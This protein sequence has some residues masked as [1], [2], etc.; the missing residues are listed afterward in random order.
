MK[1]IAYIIPYFGKLPKNFPLWLL[2]CKKNPTV[3]FILLTN[4]ETSYQY[5]FN[6]KVIYCT[7]DSIKKRFQEAFNFNICIDRPWRLSLFKPAYGEIFTSEL[8]DYDFWG[9]C[10]VDLM[11]GN[12]RK[13]IT[14]EILDSYERI[15]TKGHSTLIKNC[16]KVNR[17]Y[18]TEIKGMISYKEVFSG[19]TNYSFDENGMDNIYEALNIKYYFSPNYAHLEKYEP[20]FYLKRLPTEKLYTNKYQVF[21]WKQGNLSRIYL[22]DDILFSEDYMY[23]HFFCRPMNYK[24]GT[25]NAE[26][27]IMFPDI[28]KPYCDELNYNFVKKFGRQNKVRFFMKC[29]YYNRKKLTPKHILINIRNILNYQCTKQIT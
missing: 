25:L 24:I 15:G 1:T 10:D 18:R 14:D 8:V 29:L 7:F 13:F 19:V 22:D 5:P 27:Y 16:A 3:D 9:Y 17:R 23:I 2:S 20:S 6:V 21:I 12:I 11:W 4:D 26:S 28:V